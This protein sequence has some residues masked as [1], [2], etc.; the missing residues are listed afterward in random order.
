MALQGTV[1]RSMREH[2]GRTRPLFGGERGRSRHRGSQLCPVE[3]GDP[4]V[5]KQ[6]GQTG[7]RVLVVVVGH[8][9]GLGLQLPKGTDPWCTPGPPDAGLGT[10]V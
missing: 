10:L 4:V 8:S 7:P 3:A 9:G 6:P 2:R 5:A 1:L